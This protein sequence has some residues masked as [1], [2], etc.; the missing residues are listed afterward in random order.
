MRAKQIVS[1]AVLLAGLNASASGQVATDYTQWRGQNRDGSA[2]AFAEPK[3]WPEALLQ[4]WK[5]DVGLG[6]ATPLVVGNRVYV[7][8][9]DVMLDMLDREAATD[10][11]RELIPSA[12]GRYRVNAFLYRGYW[13]DVGT[14]ESFYD[15]NVM[16]AQRAVMLR[17]VT[18]MPLMFPLAWLRAPYATREAIGNWSFRAKAH[19]SITLG[20]RPTPLKS[21]HPL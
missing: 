2:A 13:A 15:S 16:L 14:V 7:F 12:L 20:R 11:G 5:V 17:A 8:S 19:D 3:V 10:F 6:Y 18:G 4:K 9:R 21:R 1:F